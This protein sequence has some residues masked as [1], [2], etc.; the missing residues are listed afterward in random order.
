M[1][2]LVSWLFGG[3]HCRPCPRGALRFSE[4]WR[5]AAHHVRG[6][7]APHQAP[8]VSLDP[9]RPSKSVRLRPDTIRPSAGIGTRGGQVDAFQIDEGTS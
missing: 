3:L 8:T 5:R 6:L 9:N 4:N 1:M 7:L 2:K